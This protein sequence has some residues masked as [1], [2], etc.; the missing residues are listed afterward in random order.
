MVSI[1]I[2]ELK[3]E[4]SSLQEFLKKKLKVEIAVENNVMRLVLVNERLAR[5]KVKDYVERFFYRR[6]LSETYKVRSEKD[7]IKIV[8]KKT[9]RK[10]FSFSRLSEGQ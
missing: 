3:H 5:G 9:S 10:R 4:M 1:D 8:K 6:G 2:E 7:A